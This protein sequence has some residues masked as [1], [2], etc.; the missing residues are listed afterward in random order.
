MNIIKGYASFAS[1]HPLILLA[2]G[3]LITLAAYSEVSNIEMEATSHVK[4]FPRELEVI[5][6]FKIAEDQFFGSSNMFIVV[7]IDPSLNSEHSVKDIREPEVARYIYF[8]QKKVEKLESITGSISY[9]DYISEEGRIPNTADEI[10]LALKNSPMSNTLVSQDRTTAL[11]RLRLSNVDGKEIEFMEVLESTIS[12]I[13][14][15]PGVRAVATGDPATS[16]IFLEHT[17]RDMQKTTK[18]SFLGILLLTTIVLASIRFSL[19]PILSVSLGTFW[20]FGLIGALGIKISSTMAG[21]AS[22]IMG[23]GIDFAIQIIGR[24]LQEVQGYFGRARAP[25]EALKVTLEN[26][27]HPMT[28]TTLA[29]LI[30]FRAMAL[31]QLSFMKDLATVMSIGVLTCMFSAL[32]IVPSL[33]LIL[34]KIKE[35]R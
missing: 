1:K 26:V 25:E 33:I 20:A 4:M 16:K 9:V 12:S 7:F 24:Y 18:F 14:P 19:L 34:N 31:G 5:R 10:K 35:V 29:A 30:G 3:I 23:I 6:G 2:L 11:I 22:M 17:S 27:I 15:P 32:T 28:V 8:L 21:V 13:T